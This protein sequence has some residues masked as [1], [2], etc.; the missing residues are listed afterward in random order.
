MVTP[1]PY[2]TSPPTLDPRRNWFQRWLSTNL[3]RHILLVAALLLLVYANGCYAQSF[4]DRKALEWLNRYN[5]LGEDP[6]GPITQE[7]DS[8]N[9]NTA[10][11]P[12]PILAN[13]SNVGEPTEMTDKA[14]VNLN[15][16]QA[17]STG[18]AN[19]TQPGSQGQ[20][21]A[22][23]AGGGAAASQTPSPAPVATPTPID[24]EL[25]RRLDTQLFNIRARVN[26]HGAVMSF[27]FK[28][29]YMSISVVMGA[30][31]IAA[32]A[33]FFIAQHGWTLTNQYVKTIFLVMAAATAYYGL[34]P[35][36]FQQ[37]QNISDNKALFLSYKTLEN[38]VISYPLTRTNSKGEQKEPQAFITYVDSE[39][40][41]LG[42]IAIGFDYTKISYKGAFDLTD[43]SAGQDDNKPNVNTNTTK[44]AK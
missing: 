34:F 28:A 29:Y 26:H 1:N 37:Q 40:S 12:R 44:T 15:Q 35:S 31:L 20:N 14:N 16:N 18:P 33:L 19:Q 6:Y 39:L 4:A 25:L 22:G 8:S 38:E 13:A 23:G 21:A 2:L 3:A 30:G 11:T 17:A 10:A 43:D 9:V 41:R 7:S 24:P 32:I 27:F 5:G 42:N 36:V